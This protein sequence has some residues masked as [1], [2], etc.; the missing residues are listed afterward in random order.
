MWWVNKFGNVTGP[1]SDEQIRKG[2]RGNQFTKLN[3][4]SEDRQSW[5]RIDQSVFWRPS[6]SAPEE[7]EL[8]TGVVGQ[9]I[10]VIGRN[11]SEDLSE[12]S[13]EV[14][15]VATP[16][17]SALSS[18]KRKIFGLSQLHIVML[19]A[20]SCCLLVGLTVFV[21]FLTSGSHKNKTKDL[22]VL[23]P[24]PPVDVQTNKTPSVNKPK[25]SGTDFESVKRKVV[26]IHCKEKNGTGFLV[27]LGKRKYLVTNE[28]VIHSTEEPEA[29]LIDGTK[30]KLGA[31]SIAKDRDLARYELV[32]DLDCLEVCE[33]MPNNNDEIWVYGNSMGDDVV[34]TLRGFVTGVGSKVLKVNA[35]IVGGNSGSPIIGKDGTVLAVAAYMRNGDGGR[36]WT[37][38]N[39]SFDDVRRFGVRFTNVEWVSVD[40][41]RFHEECRKMSAVDTYWDFLA[42]YLIFQTVSEDRLATLK[43]E[44]KDVDKRQFGENDYGFHEML[45]ELS[46]SLAGQGRSWTK[47][48]DLWRDRDALIKRLN[49][50]IADGSLTRE[51]AETALKE[52]DEK[53]LGTNW[54]KVKNRHREFNA[55]RKEALIMLRSFLQEESW[56]N[57]MIKSGYG[58][59]SRGGC[60]E[61]YLEGIKFFLDQNAQNL[62]D[63]NKRIR[64]LEKGDEDDED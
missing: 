24:Q 59:G 19:A 56:L 3:K 60:V 33:T 7:V 39:T 34:T 42:P 1:Y 22:P 51:N 6:G 14:E 62:K 31:L 32:D 46:K 30:I 55:K 23:P 8:P 26:L 11:E 5:V 45:M 49:E 10:G 44:H 18:P 48:T 25:N 16:A 40:Q 35:E 58:D 2:I 17:V 29:V 37:T 43:L 13:Q 47:W 41:R 54:E 4:I 27:K 28:H 9:K 50:A 53:R 38:K 64:I 57:P 12:E 52:F 61:W 20:V 21:I 36:D 63:L 15:E